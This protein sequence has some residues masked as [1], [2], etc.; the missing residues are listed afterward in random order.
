MGTRLELHTLLLSIVGS[1]YFQPP[2][3][4]QLVYP[5]IIYQ[6]SLIKSSYANNSPYTHDKQYTLTV[7][8]SNPDST[9]PDDVSRLDKCRFDRH[10]TKDGLNHDIFTLYY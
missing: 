3:S 8:D 10:F 2:A 6:R 5:C 4:I 7:I 1:V 9:I